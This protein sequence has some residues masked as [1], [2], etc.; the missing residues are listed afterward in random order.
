MTRQVI[1]PNKSYTFHDYFKLRFAAEDVLSY[2]GYEKQSARLE[3]PRSARE[4]TVLEDLYS[5]LEENFLHISLENEITRREFLIAPV[6][7]EVR[8]ITQSKLSSEYWFEY[9]HQLKGSFDY[10][11][12]RD[13]NLIVVEAKNSDLARGFTQLA[14]EMIALDKADEI[15]Q[16]LIY[17]AVTTGGVWQFAELDRV[18]KIVSQDIVTFDL[19]KELEDLMR[20]LIGVL[21][22]K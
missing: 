8:R 6:M 1:S 14:V 20:I 10:F 16:Q 5:R 15:S 19:L 18:R 11:L 7:S 12:R 4:I 22:Q 21:E 2:F 3:P 13:K 17:G 9:N